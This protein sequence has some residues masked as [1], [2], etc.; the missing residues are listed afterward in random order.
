VRDTLEDLENIVINN[1]RRGV[2]TNF[3]FPERWKERGDSTEQLFP[4]TKCLT[5]EHTEYTER[6]RCLDF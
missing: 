4:I 5:T 2:R 6:Q 3:P 1:H